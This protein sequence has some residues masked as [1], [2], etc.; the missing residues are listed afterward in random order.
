MKSSS[1]QQEK[2]SHILIVDD[3]PLVR[4]GMATLIR[5]EPNL[6]VCGQTG[7][8][9]EAL[10]LAREQSPDLAIVDLSLADG[11]GLDLVKRLRLD[12]PAVRV[13][14]C[15]MHDEALFAHRAIKAGAM[16]Y[17]GKEEATTQI[18]DAIQRVLEGKTWLSAN[19]AARM[20][21]VTS[22]GTVPC[23]ADTLDRLSNRELEV[24]RLIGTGLGTSKIAER[25]HLSIKTVET[26]RENIKK[27]LNVSSGGELNRRAMQWVLERS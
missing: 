16:G 23:D 10:A 22:R 1:A 25:L 8:I 13:L 12:Q 24:F 15:S 5:E 21:D 3:H 19:A 6:A 27:K 26:H 11:N 17:I 9:I 4:Q 7:S 2:S 18:V 14:V 20:P